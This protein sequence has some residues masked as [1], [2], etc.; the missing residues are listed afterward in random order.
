MTVDELRKALVG[1]PGDRLVVRRRDDKDRYEPV[2]CL[3]LLDVAEDGEKATFA[4]PALIC[5]PAQTV[6]A[7]V[8]A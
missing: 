2:R 7:V 5:G 4:A 8:I 6:P 3:L 1:L